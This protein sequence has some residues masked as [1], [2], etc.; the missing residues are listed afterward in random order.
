MAAWRSLK[1]TLFALFILLPGV[2]CEASDPT[3][4]IVRVDTRAEQL[5][6][7][8]GDEHGNPFKQFSRLSKAL[9]RKGQRLAFAMNAGMF[10]AD[11]S[12]V[13]LLVVEGKQLSALNPSD[14]NGNFFLKPNGVFLL[15]SSGPRVVESSEYPG[16]ADGIQFATQSG[17][18]LLRHGVI[19]PAFNPASTSKLIRNGVGVAG[20]IAYFVMSER[21]VSFHE[22]AVYFR[23]VLHCEDALYLDGV[24]SSLY[25]A[26]L[27]RN[28]Q[29]T[30]LGP[31]IG[32]VTDAKLKPDNKKSHHD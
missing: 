29:R 25:S 11:A 10:H 23:D 32:T 15:S 4:T 12:P 14:G 2:R 1:A 27:R 26:E 16:L 3:F 13:G 8:W 22:L 6:L 19:H 20:P 18:L 24:V 5:K 7:F 30:D 28:T 31:M 9:E 21:L 17:P